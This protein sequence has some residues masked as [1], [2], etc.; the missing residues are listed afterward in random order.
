MSVSSNG[1]SPVNRSDPGPSREKD[2]P[3]ENLYLTLIQTADQLSKN[4]DDLM[5]KHGV[6][7]QQY[8]V[9]RI[10]Y[11]RGGDGLRCQQIAE[12][13]ITRVPDVTRLLDRL[14]ERDLIT[15]RRPPEDRRVVLVNLTNPGK[16][17]WHTIDQEIV[18]FHRDQFGH[19]NPSEIHTLRE[20]LERTKQSFYR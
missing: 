5:K 13:L 19:L 3:E 9:L 7:Q 8:N 20:L 6:T 17:L 18:Q 15:R 10:L 4:V 2:I 14:H 11:V 16:T 1:S 12:R